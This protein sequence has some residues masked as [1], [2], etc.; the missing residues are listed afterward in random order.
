MKTITPKQ[1]T[2]AERKWY[3]VDAEGQTLGRL[4]TKLAVMLNGKNKVDFASHVDNGDYVVVINADKF[5]V[6]WKK[7]TDKMYHRHTGYLGG[8]KSTSLED[9]LKKKPTK[10][11][12]LAISGML[13][14]NKLRKNMLSRLKLFSGTEHK[15]EA[16]QPETVQL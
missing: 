11:L 13:P 6:T 2:P 5:V 4:A 3:V 14:K 8:L 7:M 15:Y 12:E 9:M 16:Q 1:C 10:A